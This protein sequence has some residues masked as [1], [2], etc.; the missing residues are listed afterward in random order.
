MA[1]DSAAARLNTSE[2]GKEKTMSEKPKEKWGEG[3]RSG[4]LR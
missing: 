4:Q 3:H 1:L 2:D